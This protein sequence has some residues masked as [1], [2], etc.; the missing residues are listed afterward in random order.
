MGCAVGGRRAGMP[1]HD[2]SIVHRYHRY[3]TRVELQRGLRQ[4]SD[5]M[6]VLLG[7][8]LCLFGLVFGSLVLSSWCAF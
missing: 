8:A 6:E 3:R 4:R 2:I 5:M 1:S 7:L